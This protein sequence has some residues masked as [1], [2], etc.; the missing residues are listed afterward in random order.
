MVDVKFSV[1]SKDVLVFGGEGNMEVPKDEIPGLMED[2]RER[3][4]FFEGIR[5]ALGRCDETANFT[6]KSTT[7]KISVRSNEMATLH[8]MLGE[9][10]DKH[11]RLDQIRILARG[12]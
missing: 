11:A 1:F 3:Q 2:I 4:R 7:G 6:F 9:A 12:D 8:R 10:H 5:S